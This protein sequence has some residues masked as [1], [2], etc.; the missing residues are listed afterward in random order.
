VDAKAEKALSN[1]GSL[2]LERTLVLNMKEGANFASNSAA[3]PPQSKKEIDGFL[4]DLKG[5]LAV[6]ESAVFI[7]AGHTDNTGPDDY[8]YEL[9]RK[10]AENV[11]K[12]LILQKKI[13]PMRVM[14]VSYGKSAPLTESFYDAS[15]H[16]RVEIL[17][18][19]EGITTAKEPSSK[20]Q[21]QKTETE[22]DRVS[23]STEKYVL[24]ETA[25]AFLLDNELSTEGF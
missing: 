12:Y 14:T 3:L 25:R 19:R 20:S 13:N 9:G 18:Y 8:N 6:G 21:A 5:D 10:R 22:G 2:Q 17:V 1:F 16:R 4:N 11:A 7:V 15:D 24:R 23:R